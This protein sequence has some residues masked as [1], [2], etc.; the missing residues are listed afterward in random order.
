MSTRAMVSFKQNNKTYARI[1]IHSDGYPEGKH[2]LISRIDKFLDTC[3]QLKGT[4]NDTRFND[5]CILAARFIAFIVSKNYEN[6]EDIGIEAKN[7]VDFTGISIIDTSGGDWGVAYYY[8]IV[9]NTAER[10]II[11]CYDSDKKEID[12]EDYEKD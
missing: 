5:P 10:P 4:L 8:D 9:C 12:K 2:G 1:Y 6:L 7:V 11:K 3:S